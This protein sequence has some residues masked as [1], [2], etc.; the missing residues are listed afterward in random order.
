[1]KSVKLKGYILA[2]LFSVFITLCAWIQIPLVVP[3]TLQTF[4]IF[5]SLL[6]LGGYFGTLSVL[7]YICL[8]LVGLPVFSGFQGGVSALLGAGGGYIIGFLCLALVYW[9]FEKSFSKKIAFS[10]GF[11][12]GII[13]CYILGA[14]WFSYAYATDKGFLLTFVTLNVYYIIPDFLKLALAFAVAR[15]TAVHLQKIK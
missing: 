9:F 3:I 8:G 15:R 1:M 10:V 7:T 6:L 11:P 12:I 2:A 13:A 5:L 14:A 4:G